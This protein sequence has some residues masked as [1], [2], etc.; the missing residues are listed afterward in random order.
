MGLLC[1]NYLKILQY[2][3]LITNSYPNEFYPHLT[4]KEILGKKNKTCFIINLY[5][6][7]TFYMR[8]KNKKFYTY[9]QYTLKIWL[10]KIFPALNFHNYFSFQPRIYFPYSFIRDWSPAPNLSFKK[11]SKNFTIFKLKN[12][13]C[14]PSQYYQNGHINV[15]CMIKNF[16]EIVYYNGITLFSN[17]VLL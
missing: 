12:L 3:I 1:I 7:L 2:S 11:C 6:L 13:K 8:Q 15:V 5:Y 16:S 4:I 17:F 14:I 10:R 9:F